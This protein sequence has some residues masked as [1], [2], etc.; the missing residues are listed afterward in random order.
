MH[1]SRDKLCGAV[2]KREGREF[3]AGMSVLA[4]R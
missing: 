3:E 2:Q 1:A 4:K